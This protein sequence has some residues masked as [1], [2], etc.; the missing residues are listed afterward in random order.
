MKN[1]KR[2]E[3]DICIKKK[4]LKEDGSLQNFMLLSIRNLGWEFGGPNNVLVATTGAP[5]LIGITLSV[6]PQ[7]VL[8]PLGCVLVASYMA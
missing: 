8:G 4:F 7:S 3:I 2:K 1:E 5:P 6:F